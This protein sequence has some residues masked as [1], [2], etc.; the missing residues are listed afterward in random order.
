MT[1]TGWLLA[2]GILLGSPPADAPVES[3]DGYVSTREYYPYDTPWY[4]FGPS[5]FDQHGYW[6]SVIVANDMPFPITAASFVWHKDAGRSDWINH[7]TVIPSHTVVY[8]QSNR[9]NGDPTVYVWCA[10]HGGSPR[11][12]ADTGKGFCL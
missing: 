1:L 4:Y 12:H 5:S 8:W 6:T 2:A 9:L 3:I 7:D 11:I 10:E